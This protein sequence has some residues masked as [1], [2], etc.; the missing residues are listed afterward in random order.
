MADERAGW[1]VIS[2][3]IETRVGKM[4][5]SWGGR[6]YVW[7]QWSRIQIAAW[8]WQLKLGNSSNQI[9]EGYTML[10]CNYLIVKAQGAMTYLPETVVPAFVFR[11]AL[12]RMLRCS[13]N[14]GGMLIAKLEDFIQSRWIQVVES[15]PRQVIGAIDASQDDM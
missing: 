6:I 7:Y 10:S 5:R 12:Y 14:E 3:V 4:V 9:L 1:S 2:V 8:C 15:F 11:M 13:A